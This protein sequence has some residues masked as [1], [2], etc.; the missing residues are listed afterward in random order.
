MKCVKDVSYGGYW[1]LHTIHLIVHD[2]TRL[3]DHEMA[4]E[5]EVDGC[6]HRDRKT[7]VIS[8]S[9]MGSSGTEKFVSWNVQSGPRKDVRVQ[10]LDSLGIVSRDILSMHVRDLRSNLFDGRLLQH[11]LLILGHAI[12]KG[13]VTQFSSLECG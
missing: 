1:R 6:D 13:R 11:I 3:R 4:A 8:S 12:H 10:A 7:R 2:D 9:D 5:E